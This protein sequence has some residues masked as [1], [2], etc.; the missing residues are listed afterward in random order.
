[1]GLFSKNWGKELDRAEDL[2]QRDLPVPA[3]EIA[4]RAARKAGPG[5]RERAEALAT[6]ARKAV[7]TSVLAKAAAAEGAGDLEDAADW[8]LAAIEQE[9]GAL[10]RNELEVRRKALLDR[11][12]RADKPWPAQARTLDVV[13]DE[14]T[15]PGDVSFH[16]ETLITML[17]DEVRPLYESRSAR[18]QEA[19][20][21]LN[22]GRAEGA[23]AAFDELAEAT[24]DDPVLRL[25]RGRARFLSGDAAAAR[26]DFAAAWE[27]LGDEALDTGGSLLVSAL[28]AEAS[29]AAGHAPDVVERLE[30]LASA[31]TGDPELCR[32]YA[33]ALLDTGRLDQAVGHLEAV[34]SLVP[35]DPEL[36]LLMAQ[37]LA[38]GGENDRAIAGLE[39]AIAPSCAGGSCARPAPHLPSFRLLARL[40]LGDGGDPERARELMARVADAQRGH[41]GSEDLGILA[42]YY[43]ATGDHGA[44]QEATAEAERL[45][46]TG[47]GETVQVDLTPGSR[48]VL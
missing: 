35:G 43:E 40:H 3:L 13:A 33:T 47:A 41:L 37:A 16:Y 7:L 14:A 26:S 27:A 5:V 20:I 44:A 10:R 1:M 19:F 12:D 21:A 24:P 28:W 34:L 18:F 17:T 46:E 39:Q 6:S 8:L 4:E 9:P 2:L 11:A 30:P 32:L 15:S 22:E 48:R 23:L 42:R 38:A 36:N 45:T 29:L 25:E 31:S